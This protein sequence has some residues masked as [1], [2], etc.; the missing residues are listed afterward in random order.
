MSISGPSGFDSSFLLNYYTTKIS[1]GAARSVSPSAI[2]SQAKSGLIPPWDSS[3]PTP[4]DQALDAKT[5]SNDPY[6]NFANVPRTANSAKDKLDQDNQKLF[7]LYQGLN[8]LAYLAGMAARDSTMGGQLPGLNTR[9]QDGLSQIQNFLSTAMFNN[10]TLLPGAKSSLITSTASVPL[11][12][13]NY[14]GGVVVKGDALFQPVPKINV[15]D[16]FTISVTKGGVA[17]NVTIDMAGINGPL[18]LDNIAAHIN[19]RLSEAGFDTRLQ[20]AVINDGSA[21]H[22]AAKAANKADGKVEVDSDPLSKKTFGLQIKSTGTEKITFSADATPSLYIAGNSGSLT[23]GEQTGRVLKLGDLDGSVS[24][25]FTNV[26]K[27]DS[28][29]ATAQATVVDG[30]GN[31]YV[32]GNTDGNFGSQIQQGDQDVYLSKYDSAGNMQW[33][34]LLGTQDKADGYALALDPTGG[35][36]VA[37]STTGPLSQNAIGGGLDSFVAKYS[38]DGTQKWL[39]QIDP[40]ANDAALAVTVDAGGNVFFGGYVNGV[41]ASGQSRSG[42]QDGYITKLDNK[43]VVQFRQQ[44]GTSGTDQVS[45]MATTGNGD[46]IVASQ[47]DGRAILSKYAGGDATSAPMWQMDLGDLQYGALGG[48]VVSGSEIYLSGTTANANL[49]AGGE[50]NIARAHAGGSDAFVF[51]VDDAGSS[52]SANFVSYVGTGSSEKA[53][54]LAVA[55]GHVY[56]TGTTRGAFDG[57][58]QSFKNT[59]NMF[60]ADLSTSGSLNWAKQYGGLSGESSGQGI[61]IDPQGSSIL[62]ALGLPRGAVAL[63][64]SVNLVDQT[65]LREGDHF[66]L[67]ISGRSEREVTIRIAG[68]ETMN[69]L[70]TKINSALMFSGSAKVTYTAQGAALQISANGGTQIQLISGLP[71]ADAL[72][73]LGI[74]PTVLAKDVTGTP[75][76]TQKKVFGLGLNAKLDLS[77]ADGAKAARA[78]MVA[79]LSTLRTA[80]RQSNTPDPI[81]G[82]TS[83]KPSKPVP[84]YLQSQLANYNFALNMLGGGRS[85]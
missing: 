8:R 46:L 30:N 52:A 19:T 61:A 69:S 18:T 37:G 25:A 77:T 28:G 36:V 21:A 5:L 47:Q 72:G 60:V 15:T 70:A 40:V 16:Q 38:A 3:I 82:T 9:F 56:L 53:G 12:Q 4:N 81:G 2:A 43:G 65:T 48:L 78:E 55:N 66:K 49:T 23:N 10:F 1:T 13:S 14:I 76:P 26:I 11:A 45:H 62:D 80:Y 73:G 24:P 42:G 27:P 50:A 32:L 22:L 67:K 75:S 29:T 54:S 41:I 59:P 44:L 79:V 7:S 74:A 84:A 85:A 57:Q 6:L 68:N 63:T 58:T 35:V 33:R 83:Q 20:R 51:R 31:V 64:Q 34:R 71:G 39:H 17:T